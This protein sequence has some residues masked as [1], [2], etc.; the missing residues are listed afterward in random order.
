M[1]NLQ[2]FLHS[3]DCFCYFSEYFILV[4]EFKAF[5]SCFCE[6]QHGNFAL[7]F[8]DFGEYNHFIILLLLISECWDPITCT[9]SSS[10]YLIS[11]SSSL[12]FLHQ[13]TFMLDLCKICFKVI[14]W[15]QCVLLSFEGK[16]NEIS[17]QAFWLSVY[18]KAGGV[19]GSILFPVTLLKESIKPKPFLVE[20]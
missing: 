10:A 16:W 2:L 9:V 1:A 17:F 20:S 5:F 4:H 15:V 13:R 8:G 6:E 18:N 11:L 19:C 12:Q 7:N 14:L 3:Q